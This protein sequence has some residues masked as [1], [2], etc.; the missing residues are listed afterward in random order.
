MKQFINIIGT[1]I[2]LSTIKKYKVVTTNVLSIYYNTSRYKIDNELFTF[3][4]SENLE[5]TLLELDQYFL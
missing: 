5:I 3:K 1:R 2:R 4:D